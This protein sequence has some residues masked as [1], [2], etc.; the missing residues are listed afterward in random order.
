MEIWVLAIISIA[1]AWV[2]QKRGKIQMKFTQR[3]LRVIISSLDSFEKDSI[4]G[5]SWYFKNF[6]DLQTTESDG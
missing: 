3:F 1:S 5:Y 6:Q 2:S 4:V